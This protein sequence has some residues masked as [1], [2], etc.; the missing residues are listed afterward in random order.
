[1]ADASHGHPLD[2]AF[3]ARD[4]REVAPALLGKTL[5]HDP[6]DGRRSG[7]IVEVEAYCGAEDPA[8][9]SYRGQ[10]PRNA[11]MFAPAGHLY[12]YRSYGIHWCANVVC[13]Q[14][15]DGC[16]VLL[17][18]LAPLDG[19]AAMYTAR[20]ATARRDRD[21][22][23]GPGKLTEA[24]GLDGSHDGVPLAGTGRVRLVDDGHQPGAVIQTT[25]IGISQAIEQ[26]WRW[27]V[28]GD[29]NVS[30]RARRPQ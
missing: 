13:G 12:V 17:R 25:R 15:G 27:Y 28:D 1:V 6:G 21:L 10:T 11:T 3:F 24:L 14:L 30:R 4:P 20:G 9:H 16:A 18:A 7:R 23:S 26:P 29:P 19:V 5:V 2:A 8:A 22:C